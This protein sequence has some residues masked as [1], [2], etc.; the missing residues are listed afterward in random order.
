MKGGAPE[1]PRIEPF[2]AARADD[3]RRLNVEWIER[4]F[5]LE[6]VDA[7]ILGDPQGLLVERLEQLFLADQPH[8][9]AVAVVGEGFDYVG[10]GTREFDV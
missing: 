10:A 7:A 3:F 5:E 6:P 4:Y 9:L 1:G 2:S 8:L